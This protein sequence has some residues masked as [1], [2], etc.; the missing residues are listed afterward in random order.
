M[1]N[2]NATETIC[3]IKTILAQYDENSAQ[4]LA[5]IKQTLDEKQDPDLS[6]IEDGDFFFY[7]GIKFIRL[8]EEQGG[9]LCM[10]AQV[11][12]KIAFDEN[13]S[14]NDWRRSSARKLLNS[15]FLDLLDKDD[16]LPYHSDLTADNGDTAYGECTDYIGLLSCDLYRKY[17]KFILLCDERMWTC[18]PLYCDTSHPCVASFVRHINS[19]GILGDWY[20]VQP[21]G[22]A[23]VC[24]FK[25][26]N[27]SKNKI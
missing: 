26:K 5:K 15:Q 23:P 14:C 13:N 6:M 25:K 10:T 11:W 8:G 4:T 1:M 9:V 20:P 21:Y 17:R 19:D 16:L 18:T 7:N 24:I 22:V 12:Y 3:R 2:N 27:S